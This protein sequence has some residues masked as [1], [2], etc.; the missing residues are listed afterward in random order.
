M[1]K[2]LYSIGMPTIARCPN[3]GSV[4]LFFS[5]VNLLHKLMLVDS[6]KPLVVIE[7]EE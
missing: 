4:V 6:N 1:V 3:C 5:S 7:L 2:L